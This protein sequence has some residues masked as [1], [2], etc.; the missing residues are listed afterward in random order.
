MPVRP[1]ISSWCSRG[2]S[3]GPE[4]CLQEASR[5]HCRARR[6][7]IHPI[8]DCT[9]TTDCVFRDIAHKKMRNHVRWA[10]WEGTAAC[11]FSRSTSCLT[12]SK[13]ATLYAVRC[14]NVYGNLTFSCSIL[15][16]YIVYLALWEFTGK[17]HVH[18]SC[19]H[20]PFETFEKATRADRTAQ[21]AVRAKQQR[22]KNRNNLW[23]SRGGG[24]ASNFNGR[25]PLPVRPPMG[26][27]QLCI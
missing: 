18:L 11:A 16:L 6:D 26:Q 12:L 1:S 5:R 27:L 9:K 7:L 13:G 20:E 4:W 14:G 3:W 19:P 23:K 24:L 22:C 10:K 21:N 15:A 25:L 2:P 8:T 17:L